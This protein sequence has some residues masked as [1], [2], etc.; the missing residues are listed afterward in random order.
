MS[1]Q[2]LTANEATLLSAG[3]SA[4][5]SLVVCFLFLK[6]GPNYK[7]QIAELT[8]TLTKLLEQHSSIAETL[9]TVS[10]RAQN[11]WRPSARIESAQGENWLILKSDREFKIERITIRGANDAVVA[12]IRQTDWEMLRSKGFRV[13]LPLDKITQVWNDSSGPRNGW[14]T[15]S[16]GVE[17]SDQ[18]GLVNLSVPFMAKSEFYTSAKGMQAWIKLTG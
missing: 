3:I 6:F 1:G 4:V 2:G 5:I 8:D 12:E 13:P 10:A 17:V 16:L 7:K 11:R 9:A 18:Q 15:G 14:A